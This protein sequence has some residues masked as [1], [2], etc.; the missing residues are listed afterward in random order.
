MCL[1]SKACCHRV[2]KYAC[3]HHLFHSFRKGN[4]QEAVNVLSETER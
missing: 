3:W 2:K 4:L 1:F